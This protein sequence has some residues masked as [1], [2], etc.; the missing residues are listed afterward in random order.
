MVRY[1]TM[2]MR[3]FLVIIALFMVL[4]GR[5]Y[6]YWMWTPQSGKWVNPKTVVKSTPKE[7]FEF[8]KSLYEAKSYDEAEKE[9]K[10]LLKNYPKAFEASES[11]YYL[12][13]IAQERGQLYGAYKAYQKVIDKYP[14]SERIQ[15]IIEREHSLAEAFIEGKRSKDV[16]LAVE[17]P[18]IEILTKVIENSSYG[19]LAPKAQYQLGLVLK[20]LQR[21]YEAEDAFSKVISTYP[22]S[23]WVI[24]S[25]FQIAECRSKLSRGAP[26]DQGSTQEAKQKYEEFIQEYPDAK[27]SSDAEKNLKRLQEQEAHSNFDIARFYEKQKSDTAAK[28]YYN[29][30]IAKY[31][32]SVWAT[33]AQE[34]LMI[35]EKKK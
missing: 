15:E 2:K 29:E 7:Q 23:E 1:Y 31:P 11:Q 4:S 26:Y 14:F 6:A 19:P 12:G 3:I 18:A 24:P 16:P 27:L 10:K 17:S 21:Y 35:M 25:Q 5:A 9:L 33:Q 30:I 28:I 8:A 34:R 22:N 13:L 32:D 20:G